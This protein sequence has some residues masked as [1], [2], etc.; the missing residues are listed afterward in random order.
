[1]LIKK[2]LQYSEVGLIHHFHFDKMSG[3]IELKLCNKLQPAGWT[4]KPQPVDIPC[5]VS[6]MHNVYIIFMYLCSCIKMILINLM[7][8]IVLFLN[9]V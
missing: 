4:I 3:S 1:M 5:K 7:V 2:N 8:Q 6:Y 9:L